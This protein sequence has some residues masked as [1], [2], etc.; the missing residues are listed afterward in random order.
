MN[1]LVDQYA[2]ALV[3]L[4]RELDREFEERLKDSSA[5]AFRLAYS[6]LRNRED[7]E[8][9]AQEAF[10]KAYQNFQ[11]LRDRTR[12]RAWLARIAWRLALDRRRSSQRRER[13][14][15]L[16]A[17]PLP[18]PTVEDLAASSEF[19]QRL[20]R[21]IEELPEK[22][23]QVLLLAAVEGRDMKEVSALLSLPEGTVKSRLFLARKNLADKLQ[24]VANSMKTS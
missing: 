15:Q 5:L 21:A 20:H 4:D 3:I 24:W 7:A 8:E 2:G 6:V 1:A 16:A 19:Q 14:D 9:V 11:S 18:A 17:D 13:R 12:F 23:R 22:L 10:L